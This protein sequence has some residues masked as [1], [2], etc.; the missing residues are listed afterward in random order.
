M[1]PAVPAA[2][3][4]LVRTQP[5]CAPNTQAL[6]PQ[7]PKVCDFKPSSPAAFRLGSEPMQERTMIFDL[8]N[9]DN[10]EVHS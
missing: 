2:T 8:P 10:D 9:P 6:N 1:K 4:S 7:A 5:C 3:T